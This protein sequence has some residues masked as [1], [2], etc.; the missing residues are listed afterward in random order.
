MIVCRLDAH[1]MITLE[2]ILR[3]V[4]EQDRRHRPFWNTR[5]DDVSSV[6]RRI[7]M[8]GEQIVNRCIGPDYDAVRADR[9][10]A[11]CSYV[12]VLPAFD[13]GS[14]RPVEDAATFTPD[15]L[16]QPDQILHRMKLALTRKVQK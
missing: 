9:V 11:G 15:R 6:G 3:R 1:L 7:G 12:R 14:V 5:A 16:R 4:S 13:F 2:R 8:N 10:A